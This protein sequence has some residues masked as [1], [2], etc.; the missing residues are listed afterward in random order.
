[1][2]TQLLFLTLSGIFSLQAFSQSCG[3]EKLNKKNIETLPPLQTNIDEELA[4]KQQLDEVVVQA[5]SEP[6]I[7]CTWPKDVHCYLLIEDIEDIKVFTTEKDLPFSLLLYPNP[8]SDF[9]HLKSS[10]P[11]EITALKIV[12][13]L[14]KTVFE[15]SGTGLQNPRID[16][17]DFKSGIYLV[18]ITAGEKHYT[19]QLVV[20]H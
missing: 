2:K 10:E 4:L 16:V 19:E 12:D 18:N 20:K 15:N 3:L 11:L 13:M 6:L 1:M 8:T 5:Y 14:G 7:I 17:S 9:V